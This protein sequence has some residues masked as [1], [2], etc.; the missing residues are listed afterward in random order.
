M[1]L[2]TDL[3]VSCMAFAHWH[4]DDTEVG[5]VVAKA[6]F[7]L[8]KNGTQPQTP[9]PEM[10][11]VDEFAG[12]PA[13]TAPTYE[14]DI[15][16]SK[17]KTDLIV[18]GAARSFEK[19]PR[20]DWP[21]TISIPDVLN[22]GF[23]V[24]GP[25]TWRKHLMRW[26][27]TQPDAVTEVPLDFALAYGGQCK[28]GEDVTFFEQNPAGQGFMTEEAAAE[29]EEWPAPQIG[30]LAEF[31][32]AKPFAQMTVCGTTPI[33]KGWLPRRARAGT[34]DAAWE[35][36][37]HPRMPLDYDLGFWNAAPLRLQLDPYLNGDEAIEISGVSHRRETVNLRLPGAKLALK[38]EV[39]DQTMPMALDT[40][41]IDL[42]EVDDGAVS[43]TLLWRAMVPDREDYLSAQIVRG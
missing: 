14:Q 29:V 32:A 34:F 20:R 40:V 26:Q 39:T 41:D 43:M 2:S 6:A 21:V 16:P 36:D 11:L 7:T 3:P 33:A 8:T 28:A 25:A 4:T 5:V 19:E 23:H 1:K 22:Y 17:P 24:R 27:L 38:S 18:R 13:S 31:M 10:T 30:L 42:S 12:D 37:R 35:R 15:A 9:P